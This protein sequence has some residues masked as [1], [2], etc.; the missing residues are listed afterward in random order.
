MEEGLEQG[1]MQRLLLQPLVENVFIHA[2]RD[3]IGEKRLYI[4]A[5]KQGGELLRIDIEDNGC[6]MPVETLMRL[7]REKLP[8]AGRR[9]EER[10]SIGIR[11]VIRRIYLVYGD[12]YGLEI[13]PLQQGTQVSLK[14]P[15]IEPDREEEAEDADFAGG[16]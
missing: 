9:P 13:H 14:L 3:I 2:F 16:G 6:G 11:N 8:S 12:A 4:R 5:Y 1:R 15:F 7:R 10:E